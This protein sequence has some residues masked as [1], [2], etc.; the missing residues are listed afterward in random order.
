MRGG[1]LG[2]GAGGG[3]AQS[4]GQT[5]REGGAGRVRAGVR[6]QTWRLTVQVQNKVKHG[7]T[8]SGSLL[9]GS[10]KS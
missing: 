10:I 6:K 9:F 1:V 8:P 3:E 2:E 7:G 5:G 4:S